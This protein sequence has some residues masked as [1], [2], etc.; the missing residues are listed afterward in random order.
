MG[1]VWETYSHAQLSHY[2]YKAS[3]H[4]LKNYVAKY[5][6]ILQIFHITIQP[7]HAIVIIIWVGY[8][9]NFPFAIS[10]HLLWQGCTIAVML[11]VQLMLLIFLKARLENMQ[12]K[13]GMQCAF[14]DCKSELIQVTCEHCC[15]SYCL[16]YC[17]ST[18]SLFCIQ[19]RDFYGSLICNMYIK[20]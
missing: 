5:G 17:N 20:N 14:H 11:T 18:L 3:S 16:R 10:I 19:K 13:S 4:Y 7:S 1:Q 15:C 2:W 6:P 12:Q 9:P 8:D